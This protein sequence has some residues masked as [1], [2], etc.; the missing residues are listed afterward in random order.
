MRG[1]D[2]GGFVAAS[3]LFNLTNERVLDGVVGDFRNKRSLGDGGN[4]LVVLPVDF[5]NFFNGFIDEIF[6]FLGGLRAVVFI[7]DDLA[8][9]V[10]DLL[11]DLLDLFL[12]FRLSFL[13]LLLLCILVD[14]GDLGEFFLDLFD[15]LLLLQRGCALGVH[16]HN[17]R[18]IDQIDQALCSQVVVLDRKS[19]IQVSR[20]I[21]VEIELFDV[22]SLR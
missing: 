11:H 6:D 1:L 9:L 19:L 16:A 14:G 8:G 15:E 21:D 3:C 12:L 17:L 5:L 4:V 7:G 20:L 18:G 13:E 2:S 22:D 10:L